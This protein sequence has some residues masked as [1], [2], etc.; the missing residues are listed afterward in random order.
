M[1]A[2]AEAAVGAAR[3][4]SKISRQLVTYGFGLAIE[5]SAVIL[6]EGKPPRFRNS[7]NMKAGNE[8]VLAVGDRC[9]LR[10]CRK[11]FLMPALKRSQGELPDGIV[12]S[13]RPTE[14][15]ERF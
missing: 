12:R 14:R 10:G 8:N 7:E 9:A 4:Y 6:F 5:S 15:L 11:R 13:L 3:S 1:D 2:V